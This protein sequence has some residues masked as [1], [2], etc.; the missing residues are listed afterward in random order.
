MSLI[1]IV[2]RFIINST[3]R[4]VQTALAYYSLILATVG[5]VWALAFSPKP[6]GF[7]VA[8]LIFPISLYFWILVTGKLPHDQESPS[9]THLLPMQITLVLLIAVSSM[10]M[11]IS[12]ETSQSEHS[13][14]KS[15]ENIDEK[16]TS[17][18][19]KLTQVVKKSK[20]TEK[21]DTKLSLIQSTLSTLDV[22]LGSTLRE[23]IE[24]LIS[25][26]LA[27]PSSTISPVKK[28]Q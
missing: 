26:A 13:Q 24:P 6:T 10:L 19:S 28:S 11:Y 15:I 21:I 18:D 14:Q 25:P 8:L 2:L 9:A 1:F 22:S 17:I 3:M 27:T 20:L 23:P 16:V 7:L 4:G 12:T 5:F